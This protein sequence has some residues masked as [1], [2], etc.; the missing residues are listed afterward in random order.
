MVKS[1][2]VVTG[3]FAVIRITGK[4]VGGLL[5]YWHLIYSRDLPYEQMVYGVF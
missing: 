4:D 1:I 2:D 5:V 3:Y